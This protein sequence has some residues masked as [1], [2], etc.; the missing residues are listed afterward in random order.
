MADLET[1][2][3]TIEGEIAK[4]E[5]RRKTELDGE[6][7]KGYD[8]AK[9]DAR[10]HNSVAIAGAEEKAR[11]A[12]AGAEE[13]AR[14]ALAGA[15]EKACVALAG[16]EEEARVA[17]K[18]TAVVVWMLV[19]V[20]A[21][22]VGWMLGGIFGSALSVLPAVLVLFRKGVYDMGKGLGGLAVAGSVK[23][24]ELGKGL[25]G[26]AVAGSVKLYELGKGP[27]GFLVAGSV[28]LY[29]LGKGL[30]GY[31]TVSILA[32]PNLWAGTIAVSLLSVLGFLRWWLVLLLL[33]CGG[34]TIAAA[35]W[36]YLHFRHGRDGAIA[37]DPDDPVAAEDTNGDDDVMGDV[38]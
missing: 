36:A 35:A 13:E 14:V 33:V 1:I 25:V 15:E 30:V 22:V 34:A 27:V 19:F 9:Q 17:N 2:G 12:L 24:Y 11:V 5:N 7:R 31:V 8:Q 32:H 28:K 37:P 3:S 6:W 4:M 16:A 18:K 26:L 38:D 21:G 10:I 23:L 29:E 20:F